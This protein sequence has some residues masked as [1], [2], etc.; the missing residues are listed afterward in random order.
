MVQ[1]ALKTA[2]WHE[3]WP[4]STSELVM[5]LNP[6]EEEQGM[7]SLQAKRLPLFV[8]SATFISVEACAISPRTQDA[9]TVGSCN[10]RFKLQQYDCAS[11][12]WA[13]QPGCLNR[14]LLC[15]G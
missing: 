12:S 11:S 1:G 2:S 5:D 3:T 15:R 4:C 9:K 6:F 10:R 13:P 8:T 7:V 14:H